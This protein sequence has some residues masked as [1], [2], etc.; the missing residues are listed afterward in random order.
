MPKPFDFHYRLR[1]HFKQQEK[2]WKW[3]SEVQVKNE[4]TEQLREE[5]LKDTYR[6]DPLAEANIYKLL[7]EAKQKLGI[8]IPVTM[9]Q[10]QSSQSTNAGIL[11]IK[12]EAH[13]VLSGPIIKSLTEKE[14]L[15][16]IAHELSHVLLYTIDNGDFEITSRIITAIGNDY[17]SEDAF[18]ETSR[19]FSLFTELYCDIGAYKVCGDAEAVISTLV[20]IETGL[21]KISA[22]SYIKQADEILCKRDKGSSGESHPESF[23][24]AKAIDLYSKKAEASYEEIS[25]MILG[26]LNLFNLNI[27]SRNEVHD[28]TRELIHL[29][30]KPKWMQSELNKA[31]YQQ[32][33]KDFKTD[34]QVMLTP[35]FKSKIQNVSNSLKDYFAYVMLDF[36]LCDPDISEPASGFMLDLAEQMEIHE[37]LG[38]AFKKELILSD[39][40]FNEFAKKA[41]TALNGILESEQEKTY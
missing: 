6:F 8:I 24:R 5:L 10:S 4:Q 2:T 27:F 28:L 1:D 32:Y 17:R 11:F 22:E 20:K 25:E 35:E 21:D 26:K 23:M 41:A 40:K 9:Y 3:F 37:F 29:L 7:E 31:H 14:L 39:K 30:M 15:A 13:L 18:N 19:L 33:F 36:A 16:L 38:K 12:N 34:S